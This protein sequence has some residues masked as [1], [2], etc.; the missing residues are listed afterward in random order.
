[1]SAGEFKSTDYSTVRTAN[2][3]VSVPVREKIFA[4][5]ATIPK[6]TGSEMRG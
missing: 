5:P 4:S 2:G 3:S 6:D 1:M